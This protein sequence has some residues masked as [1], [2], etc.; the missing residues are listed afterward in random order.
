M[1]ICQA[2][3]TDFYLANNA[4]ASYVGADYFTQ[5][6]IAFATQDYE[7]PVY[8]QTSAGHNLPPLSHLSIIDVLFN[9]G[10]GADALEII[11]KGR[12]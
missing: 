6:G 3:G 4:T 9:V 8:P 11:R 5:H 12:P 7:H 10:I 2:I 1:N